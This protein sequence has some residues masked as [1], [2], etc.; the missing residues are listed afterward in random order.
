MKTITLISRFV[1]SLILTVAF[2]EPPL[3]QLY[4]SQTSAKHRPVQSQQGATHS[5]LNSS[6]IMEATLRKGEVMRDFIWIRSN[7]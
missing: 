7:F 1:L 2:S 5:W 6:T 3:S 4:S